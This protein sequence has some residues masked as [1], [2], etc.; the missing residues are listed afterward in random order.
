M[1]FN[2][3]PKPDG[4]WGFKDVAD[5]NGETQNYWNVDEYVADHVLVLAESRENSENHYNFLTKWLQDENLIVLR[6][7]M[8]WNLWAHTSY[9]L[10]R[11]QLTILYFVVVV[12]LS[13]N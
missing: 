8:V 9:L 6:E 1:R 7:T 10:W 4:T 3:N 12:C 5:K 2:T 11:I 13:V